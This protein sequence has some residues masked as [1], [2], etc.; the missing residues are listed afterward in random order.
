MRHPEE[1]LSRTIVAERVWGGV[2]FVTDNVLDVTVSGLRQKLARSQADKPGEQ[3]VQIETVRGVGYRLAI[4]DAS[5][6]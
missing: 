5:S 6:R 1:V 3:E 4:I 2:D